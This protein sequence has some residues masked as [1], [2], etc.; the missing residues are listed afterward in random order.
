MYPY[1]KAIHIIF[2]ITWFAGLFYIT[3][4]FIYLTEAHEKLEPERSILISQLK[5]MCSR[6]WYGITWP[7]AVVTLV[8]GLTLLALQ[9]SWLRQDFMHL[10]LS[11]VV[12]LYLYHFSLQY[13]FN[14]LKK[15]IAK[16]SSPQLRFWNEVA[17]LFL[18]SIVFVI[19]L[20]DAL[21]ITWGVLGL[22]MLVITL[23]GA[24]KLYRK[25]RKE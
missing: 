11:L 6:L 20:K 9:P 10:K 14:L 3:R 18:V 19:V 2:I 4:L 5:T 7:S 21:S 22:L 23:F 25:W 1:I 24:I 13:L 16:Y 8:V 15:D 12:L 17:T